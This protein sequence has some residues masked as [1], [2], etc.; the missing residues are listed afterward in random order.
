MDHGAWS[1]SGKFLLNSFV[2]FGLD[3]CNGRVIDD[4]FIYGGDIFLVYC[5]ILILIMASLSSHFKF[6]ALLFVFC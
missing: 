4:D 3:G 6:N 5:G 1:F 2:W